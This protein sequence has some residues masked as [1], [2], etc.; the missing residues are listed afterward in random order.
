[1]LLTV[2]PGDAAGLGAQ[3]AQQMVVR[4]APADFVT[5]HGADVGQHFHILQ[6][7]WQTDVP[8]PEPLW[9]EQDASVLGLPFMVMSRAAGQAA[10]DFPIYNESGFLFDAPVDYRRAAW[11]ASVAALAKVA[12]LDPTRFAFLGRPDRG[13][14][15]LEQFLGYVEEAY[16]AACGTV[17]T[18]G[19][20]GHEGVENLLAWLHDHHAPT[21][22]EGVSWGDARMGNVLIDDAAGVTALVDWDRAMLGGPLADLGW[23]LLF[24]RMHDEDYGS[25]RLVGLGTREETL[26]LWSQLSGLSADGVEWYEILAATLLSAVRLRSE[27]MRAEHG[28]WVPEPDNPRGADRLVARARRMITDF[29]AG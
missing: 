19:A 21:V 26:L 29:E 12:R 8:S 28:F 2:V 9:L 27:R 20:G 15:G 6:A 16:R 11:R 23:W 25:P 22:V 4:L 13:T 5:V 1:L 18:D 24:D 10:P 7:L 3:G 17:G 14:T